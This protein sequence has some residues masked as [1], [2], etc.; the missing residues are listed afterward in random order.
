[1]IETALFYFFAAILVVS[2]IRVVTAKN[3][4]QAALF[5]ILAFFTCSALWLLL[6]AEFLA[7]ILI[8]VYVGAVMVLF[9]FVIMMLDINV[10]ELR[11]GFV[12]YL[13]IGIVVG[14]LVIA[15]VI[16]V[17]IQ[18]NITTGIVPKH[19]QGYSNTEA[20]GRLIYGEYLFAFELAAAV[21]L[22]ALVAAVVLVLKER[23]DN[24]KKQN[25]SKQIRVQA[26]DRMYLV[27]L[28]KGDKDD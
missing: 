1:M 6:E 10:A 2:A 19:P 26:K 3:P 24:S 8:L 7:I 12:K 22:V 17:I 23:K 25:I 5:L 13:P 18:A 21:L 14:L 28:P 15:E 20:L 16:A 27:D 4:V 11:A 9:L